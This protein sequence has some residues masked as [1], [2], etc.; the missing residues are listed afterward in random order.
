[1]FNGSNLISYS[2]KEMEQVRGTGIS[3]I[4]QEPLTSLNPLFTIGDQL[5]EAIRIKLQRREQDVGRSEE[6]IRAEVVDWLKRVDL[7]DPETAMERY[8]HEWSGGMRQ[9]VMIAMALA[10][11]PGLMLADEPTSALDWAHGEQV[12]ELV[13]AVARERNAAVMVVAH[14]ARIIPFADR[15]LHLEDGRLAEQEPARRSQLWSVS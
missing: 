9:R 14:D 15:V 11:R 4:F 10:A 8:P 6:K 12:I 7:A 5:S 3:M 2:E 13:R 1:M